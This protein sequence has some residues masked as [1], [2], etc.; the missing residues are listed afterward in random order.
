MVVIVI[1]IGSEVNYGR[2]INPKGKFDTIQKYLATHPDT[3][4]IYRI[5]KD[6]N[7][8]IIAHGKVD[9]L[10]AFPSS[11]PAYVFDS[12]GK[13]VDWANDP[14]DNS[15]FQNKWQS[16]KREPVTRNEIEKT[17]QPKPEGDGKPAP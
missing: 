1:W 8:Y 3:S 11:P 2:R 16:N 15:T 7:Q 10:L 4:R 6:R 5:E 12:S 9:A 17:F 13:L 14:G